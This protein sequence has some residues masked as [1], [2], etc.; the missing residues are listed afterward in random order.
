MLH[1]HDIQETSIMD[2]LSLFP[3]HIPITI[4]FVYQIAQLSR[5]S[6][7]VPVFT[8]IGMDVLSMLDIQ[9]VFALFRSSERI[10][11]TI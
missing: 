8:G 5:K 1:A 11:A 3:T 9:N 2:E 6:V 4:S 10:S 7:L